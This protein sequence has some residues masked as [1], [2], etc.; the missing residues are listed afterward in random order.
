MLAFRRCPEPRSATA[1]CVGPALLAVMTFVA[2]GCRQRD[3]EPPSPESTGPVARL[4]FSP[5]GGTVVAGSYWAGAKGPEKGGYF[6]QRVLGVVRTWDV[7]TGRAVLSS[8]GDERVFGE[9]RGTSLELPS[10][11]RVMVSPDGRRLAYVVERRLG[12]GSRVI[13]LKDTVTG[14]DLADFAFHHGHRAGCLAF[15][16]D[17]QTLAVQDGESVTFCGESPPKPLALQGLTDRILGIAFSPDGR[18]LA[19][20]SEHDRAP[21]ELTVW[22]IA[23]GQKVFGLRAHAQIVH[24]LTFSPDGGFLAATGSDDGKVTVWQAG[25]GGEVRTLPGCSKMVFSQDG[26]LLAGLTAETTVVIW[27]VLTGQE[28]RTCSEHSCEVTAMAFDSGGK[29][30]VTGSKDGSV[31]VWDVP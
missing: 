5:D 9:W 12:G 13:S 16:P 26:H 2:V 11:G 15:S 6:H 29:R 31:K 23:T 1:R 4:A 7:S 18:R 28:L 30:L 20:A 21:A 14:E 3:S 22:D 24:H 25:T 10:V 8:R 27:D 19:C 17:G